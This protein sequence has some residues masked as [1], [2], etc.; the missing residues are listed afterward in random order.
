MRHALALVAV[1]CYAV[2]KMVIV[3]IIHIRHVVAV[4]A[5]NG[6]VEYTKALI[7]ILA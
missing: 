6:I 1:I 4:F 7:W 2:M 3:C 5:V